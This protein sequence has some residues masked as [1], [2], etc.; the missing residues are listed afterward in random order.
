MHTLFICKERNYAQGHEK[1]NYG[2]ITS[3]KLVCKFL[4]Q[5]GYESLVVVAQDANSIDRLV[6]QY[7]PKVVIIE[8]LWVTPDKFKELLA[9]PRHKNRSW[10]VRIHSR[11][12]FLAYD[13]VAVEWIRAYEELPIILAPNTVDT[14]DTISAIFKHAPYTLPNV[15]VNDEVLTRKKYRY[16]KT[17]NVGC[18]GA[19]R[20]MKN[21]IMQAIAAIEYGEIFGKQIN[22]HVNVT[23]I[24]NGGS[25][26]LK[27]LRELF[28][29]SK[30]QLI[31]HSWLDY[32]DFIMLVKSMDIGIQVSFSETYN[33]VG[34]DFVW[35]EIPFVG[36]EQIDWLSFICCADPNSIDDI[37]R[38]MNFVLTHIDYQVDKIAKLGLMRYNKVAEKCWI[39]LYKKIG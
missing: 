2:L 9:I 39:D 14:S 26:V 15:Y 22:F 1:D 31:E 38:R 13:S 23:R 6:T 8:A 29:E 28:K 30:H 10:I 33:I 11:W 12:P 20:P 5:K 32:E 27:N 24:E 4:N 19:I 35:Y 21:H 25:S 34:A 37:V 36:S 17:L 16:G 3:S 7:D 18:F